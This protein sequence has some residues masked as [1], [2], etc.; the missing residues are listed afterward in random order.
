M[1]L[2]I[3]CCYAFFFVDY[4]DAIFHFLIYF[5]I[6][7]IFV[8][9]SSPPLFSRRAMAFLIFASIFAIFAPLMPL[10]RDAAIIFLPL[11]L[12]H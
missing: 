12:R 9:F 1:L 8:Y 6:D 3:R 4:F 11:M 10:S 2:T 5:H 7:F